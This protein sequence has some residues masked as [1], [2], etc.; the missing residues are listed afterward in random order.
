MQNYLESYEIYHLY[1]LSIWRSS[2][3]P[4]VNSES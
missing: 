2:I 3:L 4:C 1:L